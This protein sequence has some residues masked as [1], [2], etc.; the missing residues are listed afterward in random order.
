MTGPN[1]SKRVYGFSDGGNI[2]IIRVV[3]TTPGKWQWVSKSNQADDNGLNNHKGEF[4]AIEWTEKEKKQNP[5]RRG[6]IR[7]TSNGHAL[8]YADGTPF[9][10]IGDTWLAGA[11]W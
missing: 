11:T 1:T 8:Q 4:Q 2:Y 5:N 6:F 7:P 3:A 10:L 9:F